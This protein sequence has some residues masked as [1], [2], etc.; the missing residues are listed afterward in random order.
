[1]YNRRIIILSDLSFLPKL[2]KRF[3]DVEFQKRESLEGLE[4]NCPELIVLEAATGLEVPV[5]IDNWDDVG[6]CG[7]RSGSSDVPVTMKMLVKVG[8]VAS[9]V[10]IRV[11]EDYHEDRALEETSA[12]ISGLLER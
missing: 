8:A 10:L 9:A 7:I 5:M 6:L 11:P 4:D 2:C 12:I 3:P 1:M